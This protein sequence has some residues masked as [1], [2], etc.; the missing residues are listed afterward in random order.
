MNEH[1]IFR[2]KRADNGEW[3]YGWYML[4]EKTQFTKIQKPVIVDKYSGIA[5]YIECVTIGRCT[6]LKDK[7]GTLIFEGD[8]VKLPKNGF[9]AVVSWGAQNENRESGI[10]DAWVLKWQ[11]KF[12]AETLRNDLGYW[13]GNVVV[14]GN[15]HDNTTSGDK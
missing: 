5:E 2:G 3:V 6:G 8:I 14:S 10:D 12:E 15:I 4:S 11:S 7:Y 9:T 1:Y 13:A